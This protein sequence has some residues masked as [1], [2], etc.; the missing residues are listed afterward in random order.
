M[1]LP[2]VL[3]TSSHEQIISQIE[4]PGAER[5]V[6][7]Y[8][9]HNPESIYDVTIALKEEDFNNSI[10]KIIYQCM[11]RLSENGVEVSLPNI[12][13]VAKTNDILDKTGEEYLR[14]ISKSDTS[15]VDVDYNAQLVLG[16]SIKRQAYRE[17]L[18]V[19][20]DCVKENDKDFSDVSGFIGTQQ[21]RFMNLSLKSGDK[22]VH[23]AE[24]IDDWLKERSENPTSVPGLKT[25]F[26]ELDE[27]IGGFR[28]GRLYVFAARSKVG[29]SLLL[30]N[31]AIRMATK[32][33]T[34][35]LYLD[36]EMDTEEDVRPRL[37]AIISG[38]HED[39]IQNGTYIYNP[40]AKE[41][42][43]KAAEILKDTPFYH[44]YIPNFTTTQITSLVRKYYIKHGIQALFFD[45]IKL[46]MSSSNTSMKEYQ[47]LGLLTGMLKD[48]G[49]E[50]KI[51]VITAA[52]LNR[53]GVGA[54]RS[55]EG[56]DESMVGGS[57]RIL[58]YAS[59]LFYLWEKSQDQIMQDGGTDAGN[60]CLRLGRSRHGGDYFAWLKRHQGNAR[61]TEVQKL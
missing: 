14:R 32:E 59:Y 37:L 46:P 15:G 8:I 61:I 19:L 43:E 21:Q 38:V 16:A 33:K 17:G 1:Y 10:N 26:P 60:L 52:Q 13:A 11:T 35:I 22:V 57:D 54:G 25:G 30:N 12:L 42:V 2:E 20:K 6:L 9:L 36:T 5:N 45:Y 39:A 3:K 53:D 51:P 41:A 34:P 4:R 55:D 24:G 28:D 47:M 56:P 49:G 40:Q 58:H 50:L 23:I 18:H 29:K 31:F 48:L 27:A 44:A 7:A